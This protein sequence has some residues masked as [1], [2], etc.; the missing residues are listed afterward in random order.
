MQQFRHFLLLMM[1]SWF[2]L[3]VSAQEDDTEYRMEIGG[4][5]GVSFS[6]NDLNSKFYGNSNFTGGALLRYQLS[7]RMAL[8]TTL[9]YTKVSGNT[10]NVS[11]FYPANPEVSG[12]DRLSFEAK[13]ALYDLS[14]LY[15]INFLPYGY[16]SG[17]QGFHR[18]V[19]YLQ[20]GI[21]MIYSDAGSAFSLN[22]PLGFGVKYKIGRRLNLGLEWRMHLTLSDKI[23]GLEAPVG[24]TSSG[25][26]NKDHHNFTMLTLTYD[27][28]PRCPTCNKDMP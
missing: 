25:F 1:L 16:F 12:T 6:L 11:N 3:S 14:A 19:P 4:G 8:K 18:L 27:I 13:G 5:V 17:Y 2:A 9:N 15:E 21:G 28:S 20:M 23:E 24:I 26:R 10:Q 22:I 7:P